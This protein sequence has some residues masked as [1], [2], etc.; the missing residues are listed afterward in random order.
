MLFSRFEKLVAFRYLRSRKAEGFVSVIAG[1][2]FTGIMLGVATLII[3]MSVMN[4]FRQEL[5]SRIL[6]LNGHMN[7]Y[8]V[9]GSMTNYDSLKDELIFMDGIKTAAPILE[10]QALISQNSMASGVLVR[11]I[12][13]EDFKR[14]DILANSIQMGALENM[15]QGEVAIG[16][17]LSEKFKVYPGDKIKLTSPQTK[18]TPFGNMPVSRTY[19]VGLVFDVGMY[20]YDNNF[21]FLPWEKHLIF[22]N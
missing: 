3:V 17:V 22:I 4:G 13:T 18:S 5:F 16:K 2:S 20:E 21:I 9:T 19:T 7:L 8:A 6:G 15:N 10:G 11:G 12:R 1:F 14:R